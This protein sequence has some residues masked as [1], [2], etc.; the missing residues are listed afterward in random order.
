MSKKLLT[1]WLIVAKSG[2]VF[3]TL[4]IKILKWQRLSEY[5]T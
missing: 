3:F 4:H 5:M 1:K 2:E